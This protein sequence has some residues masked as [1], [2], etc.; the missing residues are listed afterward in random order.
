MQ[1]ADTED[2]D[3]SDRDDAFHAIGSFVVADECAGVR[4]Q[5][6]QQSAAGMRDTKQKMRE[7]ILLDT[8]SLTDI[9]AIP[10]C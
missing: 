2:F 1:F 8:G 3:D 4:H 5:S 10:I 7:W 9:F 6:F